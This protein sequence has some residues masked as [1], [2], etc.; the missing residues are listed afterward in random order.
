MTTLDD[1]T[2]LQTVAPLVAPMGRVTAFA[3]AATGR[4]GATGARRQRVFALPVHGPT[5]L[6]IERLHASDERPQALRLAA[7]VALEV[8]GRRATDIVLRAATAPRVVDVVVLAVDPT[9]VYVWNTWMVDGIE[10]AW[11]GDAGMRI[12]TDLTA[13]DPVVRLSCRDGVEERQG[14]VPD[15]PCADIAGADTPRGGSERDGTERDGTERDDTERD[16]LVVA[17]TVLPVAAAPHATPRSTASTATS[18][19]NR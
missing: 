12:D 3:T 1:P 17:V 9:V 10:H 7:A 5:R 6:R 14:A 13:A 15:A 16:D 11:L 8:N 19:T 18:A 2:S 4:A